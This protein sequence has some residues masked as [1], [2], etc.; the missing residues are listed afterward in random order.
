MNTADGPV[1][2]SVVVGTL[3]RAEQLKVCVNSIFD[4]TTLSTR[5][6]VTDAGSS[7]GT[8][9]YLESIASDRLVPVLQG[10]RVG[11]ARAYNEVF[12]LVR[13]PYVCWLSDDNVVV[14]RGLD[15]AVR[16]LD[17]RPKIGMVGLKVKDVSGPFVDAPYV[18]G[19]S[20]A[21]VL[22]VNQGVLRTSVIRE[23]G[24]FSERFR[25]YGIDPD[26]TTRVI[27]TGHAVVHTRQIALH[28]YRNWSTDRESPDYIRQQ[29]LQKAYLELYRRKYAAFLDV[30]WL[31]RVKRILWQLMRHG[32]GIST[33]SRRS[34]LGLIPRDWHNLFTGRY[35][36]LVD[37]IRCLR[38]PYH[39]LQYCP[40][41]KR[42]TAIPADP[43]EQ[44]GG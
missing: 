25:D 1:T 2:L 20:A 41:S 22:N 21:G 4:Q 42:P 14:N 15:V 5:V 13:T 40:P 12:K 32:L 8:I 28:H 11:Q 18:G 9:E 35:I 6:Y 3:N 38:Q 7:D 29:E 43:A 17:T 34:F 10:K 33:D 36:S 19:V 26:L 16:I 31:T 30:E 27:F 23:L 37:P 44:I 39:L 24:G